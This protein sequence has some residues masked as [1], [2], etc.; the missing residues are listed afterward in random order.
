MRN[1]RKFW[2]EL[3]DWHKSAHCLVSD[4]EL[5]E[6]LLV[7]KSMVSH[8]RAGRIEPPNKI[9]ILLLDSWGW[10]NVDGGA[11]GILELFAGPEVRMRAES[12]LNKSG[13]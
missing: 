9:K 11:L 3:L 12:E 5:A 1:S 13:S 8:M 6:R 4:T 7:S 10:S 2:S